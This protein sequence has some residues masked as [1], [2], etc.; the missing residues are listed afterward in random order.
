MAPATLLPAAADPYFLPA[1]AAIFEKFLPNPLAKNFVTTYAP[2]LIHTDP[3]YLC[4]AFCS[5]H[6]IQPFRT[7]Y[8]GYYAKPWNLAASTA[9]PGQNTAHRNNTLFAYQPM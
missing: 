6:G 1:L 7:R 8:Q 9:M 3:A 4:S 5:D 2:L